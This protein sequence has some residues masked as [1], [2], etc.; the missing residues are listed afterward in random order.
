M[1]LWHI[2]H[3]NILHWNFM[4]STNY[5]DSNKQHSIS[6]ECL[7]WYG[8]CCQDDHK[9]KKKG[10]LYQHN[11]SIDFNSPQSIIDIRKKKIEASNQSFINRL[12][13]NVN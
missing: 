5:V 13:S 3:Q 7:I 8:I 10:A 4:E 6:H 1:E 12:K 11:H 9:D 2:V